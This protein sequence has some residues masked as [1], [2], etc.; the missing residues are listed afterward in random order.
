MTFFNWIPNDSDQMVSPW[1]AIY[2]GATVIITGFTYFAWRRYVTQKDAE[3]ER[4]W[5]GMTSGFENA[6]DMEN[7]K[8]R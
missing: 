2:C 7:G 5:G 8:P 4:E 1:F 3:F 6:S